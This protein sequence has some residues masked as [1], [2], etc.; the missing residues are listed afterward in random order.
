MAAGLA[1]L[2]NRCHAVLKQPYLLI[3][4]T[5]LQSLLELVA[6]EMAAEG[7]RDNEPLQ[8]GGLFAGSQQSCSLTAAASSLIVCT[9]SR[10]SMPL[11]LPPQAFYANTLAHIR[12][13]KAKG[14][15]VAARYDALQV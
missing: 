15:E 12:Q 14:G 5:V 9:H 4:P 13:Q 6:N 7:C 3:L 8:V 2:Q 1:L 10:S 11:G